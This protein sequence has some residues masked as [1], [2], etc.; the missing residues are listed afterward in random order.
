MLHQIGFGS[1]L[2][3]HCANEL[4]RRMIRGMN[5]AG[6]TAGTQRS[7]LYGV[8]QRCGSKS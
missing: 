2:H 3:L 8:R 7:H 4:R 6:F 1:N 5:V